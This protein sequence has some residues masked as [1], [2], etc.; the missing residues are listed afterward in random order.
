[1]RSLLSPLHHLLN[2]AKS[3]TKAALKRRLVELAEQADDRMKDQSWKDDPWLSQLDWTPI[4]G[5]LW[6]L[7]SLSL[8]RRAHRLFPILSSDARSPLLRSPN[9]RHFG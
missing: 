3:A 4:A 1:M 9:Q 7:N 8:R 5:V 2:L 6:P